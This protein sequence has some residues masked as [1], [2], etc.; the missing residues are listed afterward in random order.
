MRGAPG[1][2]GPVAFPPGPSGTGR[3]INKYR[4]KPRHRGWPSLPSPRSHP[5]PQ[6]GLR[7]SFCPPQTLGHNLP[8]LLPPFPP[9]PFLPSRLPRWLLRSLHRGKNPPPS[10]VSFSSETSWTYPGPH[11]HP[12]ALSQQFRGC[13]CPH[14]PAPC[15]GGGDT[16]RQG[17]WDGAPRPALFGDGGGFDHLPFLA[18]EHRCRGAQALPPAPRSARQPR[19]FLPA[20]VTFAGRSGRR[21]R[22]TPPRFLIAFAARSETGKA[23]KRTQR[24][25]PGPGSREAAGAWHFWGCLRGVQRCRVY[26]G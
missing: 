1:S 10:P 7:V 8:P 12:V 2:P 9:C 17:L 20:P 11:C 3:S 6:G 16:H 25:R 23:Q 18:G 19:R 15:Q 22:V 24:A 13:C 26:G 4:A 14:K 5:G 21:A